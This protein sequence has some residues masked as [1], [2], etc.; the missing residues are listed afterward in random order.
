MPAERTEF[1]NYLDSFCFPV[2]FVSSKQQLWR[3][4]SPGILRRAI[5]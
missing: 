1:C 5:W 2:I 3:F 4:E